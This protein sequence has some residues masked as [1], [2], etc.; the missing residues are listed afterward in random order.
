MPLTDT[1]IRKA[2]PTATPQKLRDGNGLY[3]LLRPDDARWWRYDYRRPVTGKRNTLSFGTYPEVSLSDARE[4]LAEAR[5]L[6]AA[7][8]DPGE[9]RKAVKA[10]GEAAAANSFEVV[11]REW[12]AKQQKDWSTQYADKII[13]RLQSDI[14]PWIGSSPI[15]AIT[16]P[17]LL[18]HLERI[19]QGGAIETAHRA[20]QTCGA[21]FRY[22]VRTGRAEADPTGALKGALTPWRSMPFAA[23]TT[24][25]EATTVLRKIDI[26]TS[27]PVV[28]SA[29]QLA[30]LLFARPGELV[31]MRWAELDLDAGHWR[32]FVTKTKR[33]HIAALSTQAVEIL[34]DLYP[35]TGRGE[36]VFP[37]GRDPRKHMSGNAILVAARRCGIEKDESTIHGFRHMASTLLNEMGGWTPDAIESALT[38]KMPGVRGIYNQAQYLDER[39]KM[40]QAWGDYIQTLRLGSVPLLLKGTA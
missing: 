2:K 23:A 38:H 13:R 11:A 4:R 27:R 33:T 24:S 30:P 6:L 15:A 35:L 32:Y 8:I 14:F 36:F 3:L 20:L 1:A 17:E 34:R 26:S 5:R 40:M 28:R 29:L 10:A 16:A 37:G 12:F 39:R 19:E 18:K 31:R 7:K 25:E 22:A 9:Q 21:V